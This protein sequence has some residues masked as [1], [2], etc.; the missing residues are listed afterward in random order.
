MN[1]QELINTAIALIAAMKYEIIYES[2]KDDLKSLSMPEL[3]K[4]LGF[5]SGRTYSS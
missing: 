4:K 1:V 2:S 5:V 3:E